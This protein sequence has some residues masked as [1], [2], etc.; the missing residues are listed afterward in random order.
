[1]QINFLLILGKFRL[2]ITFLIICLSNLHSF[3]NSQGIGAEI[4]LNHKIVDNMKNKFIPRIIS[5]VNNIT[6]PDQSLDLNIYL[7]KVHLDLKDIK[8]NI[9]NFLAQNFQIYF[10]E[11]NKINL[12]L[13]D[14]S[15]EGKL[16]LKFS[17]LNIIKETLNVEIKVNKLLFNSV[18]EIFSQESKIDKGK[19]L[20]SLKVD[21]V[22]L[23]FNLDLSIQGPFWGKLANTFKK[24][25]ASLAKKMIISQ[26]KNLINENVKKYV[27]DFIPKQSV[28]YHLNNTEFDLDYSLVSPVSIYNNNLH[29]NSYAALV[30]KKLNSTLPTDYKNITMTLLTDKSLIGVFS[31]NPINQALSTLYQSQMLNFTVSTDDSEKLNLPVKLNT[32][33]L[34]VFFNDLS[35]TNNY[36]KDAK[37]KFLCQVSNLPVVKLMNNRL[38]SNLEIECLLQVKITGNEEIYDDAIKFS[39]RLNIDGGVK[40]LPQGEIQASINYFGFDNSNIIESKVSKAEISYVEQFLDFA[41]EIA[42]PYLNNK[43]LNSY[44]IKL[45]QI[46]GI[47]LEDS[48]AS[49]E[50]NLLLFGVNPEI[51]ETFVEYIINLLQDLM[52]SNKSNRFETNEKNVRKISL[53]DSLR[54]LQ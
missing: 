22:N 29:L 36:G 5:L 42:V 9:E 24:Q 51:S 46:Y 23:D 15:A 20:P 44:K 3:I 17:Y 30:N 31:I 14:T 34:D 50:E 53:R 38:V 48:L 6:I 52:N 16:N 49:I 4:I 2:L 10:N 1:L 33:L 25:I 32:T 39:F 26:V 18:F 40:L 21:S 7:G 19:F 12:H 11:T 37:V 41:S 13:E 54:F 35:N 45:P 28:Y 47:S 8:F 27:I 43:F